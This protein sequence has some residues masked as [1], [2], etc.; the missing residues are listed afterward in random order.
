[1]RVLLIF[2][3]L[4]VFVLAGA[5]RGASSQTPVDLCTLFPSGFS[6]RVPPPNS[7]WTASDG[8]RATGCQGRARCETDVNGVC[9]I[10]IWLIKSPQ[11]ATFYN[12]HRNSTPTAV[13][14]PGLGTAGFFHPQSASVARVLFHRD[15]YFVAAYGEPRDE[16]LLKSTALALDAR[17]RALSAPPPPVTNQQPVVQPTAV[18][19]REST[20]RRADGQA[21]SDLIR[22][23]GNIDRIE[24]VYELA[25]AD[26]AKKAE[27]DS[28]A[29]QT[30]IS[31][32]M[33]LTPRDVTPPSVV[34]L[35]TFAELKALQRDGKPLL[36]S[37]QNRALTQ[38][39]AKLALKG[40]TDPDAINTAGRLLS[41]VI[42][43]DLAASGLRPQ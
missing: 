38:V 23:L 16:G 32:V 42:R 11:A 25:D 17:I 1:M 14:V 21:E 12:G 7:S 24:D 15:G 19:S 26:S 43:L 8:T 34:L 35:V 36:P 6:F 4:L 18:V 13:A 33:G 28:T 27:A 2:P 37:L 20:S 5:P 40:Q 30:E 41:L 31:K 39:I 22:A 29:L 10:S 3:L 9:G